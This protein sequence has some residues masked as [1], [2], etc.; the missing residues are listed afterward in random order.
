M[1]NI[2]IHVELAERELPSKLFLALL[3]SARG[4]DVV[5][6][7]LG[8]LVKGIRKGWFPPGILHTKSL[9]P[10]K[11]KVE[12]FEFLRS[13]GIKITSL[14]EESGVATELDYLRFVRVRYSETTLALASQAFAWGPEECEAVRRVYPSATKKIVAVGSPRVDLWRAE[15][16]GSVAPSAPLPEKPFVL[17]ISNFLS[18]SDKRAH[19][20]LAVDRELGYVD[21]PGNAPSDYLFRQAEDTKMLAHFVSAIRGLSQSAQGWEIVVRPHPGESSNAWEEYLRDLPS[22]SVIGGGQ[23]TPWILGSFALI[24]NGST[25][26]FESVLL[27]KPTMTFAPFQ[28]E[29]DFEA[30]N[31][32]GA[33][34]S[35][36]SDLRDFVQES[37]RRKDSDWNWPGRSESEAVLEKRLSSLRGSYASEKIV[38]AWEQHFRGIPTRKITFPLWRLAALHGITALIR[39]FF[40]RPRSGKYTKFAPINLK[41]TLNQIDRFKGTIGM[42]ENVDVSRVGITALYFRR[43]Q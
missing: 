21:T 1:G 25:T 19:E 18:N 13:K 23:V 32:I 27:G 10:T 42:R 39:G 31:S 4:H 14:D 12:L 30:A 37:F 24:H 9:T 6:G 11:K 15:V 26:A 40:N 22:V 35:S 17:V 20:I 8:T 29:F 3:A 41:S 38:V 16:A 33:K 43:R 2:Y 28:R 36:S 7:D 34:I 5:V